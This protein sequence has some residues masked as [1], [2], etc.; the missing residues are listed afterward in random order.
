ME[1][2]TDALVDALKLSDVD[3]DRLA[4]SLG[5]MESEAAALPTVESAGTDCESV[6]ESEVRAEAAAVA[7]RLVESAA[8]DCESEL[9]VEAAALVE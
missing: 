8:A 9:C 7:E 3:T 2:E 5:V 4:D 6:A 1:F